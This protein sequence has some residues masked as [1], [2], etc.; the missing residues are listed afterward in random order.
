MFT[1]IYD[2]SK[3]AELGPLLK[4]ALEANAPWLAP[5]LRA[6]IGGGR[7]MLYAAALLEAVAL[8]SGDVATAFTFGE[9]LKTQAV[10]L[11]SYVS[12][13]FSLGPRIELRQ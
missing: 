11:K 4:S 3:A 6:K 9:L 1:V 7:W 13:R 5:M 10:E 12:K 2:S 8:R